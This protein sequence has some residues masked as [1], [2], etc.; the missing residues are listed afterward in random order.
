MVDVNLRRFLVPVDAVPGL[1]C[2]GLPIALC[3]K[4]MPPI[5]GF[6]VPDDQAPSG[7]AAIRAL[8]LSTKLPGQVIFADLSKFSGRLRAALVAGYRIAGSNKLP[9]EFP[10]TGPTWKY[11]PSATCWELDAG[12]WS[13]FFGANERTVATGQYTRVDSL[14]D[15]HLVKGELPDG[16]SQ[17]DAIALK[18]VIEHIGGGG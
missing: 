10:S 6:V 18:L 16:T 12:L 3:P 17:R 4:G 9:R 7:D 8:G 13:W 15:A 14:L 11:K 2:P 1:L 5:T